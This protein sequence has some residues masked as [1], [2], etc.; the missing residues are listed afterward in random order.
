MQRCR[1]IA[2]DFRKFYFL[3][4]QKVP[5]ELRLA[6]PQYPVPTGRGQ[7]A[8][9]GSQFFAVRESF[10]TSDSTA[11]FS[12]GRSSFWRISKKPRP[13]A[14]F[15][16]PAV[17]VPSV[18]PVARSWHRVAGFISGISCLCSSCLFRRF[19]RRFTGFTATILSWLVPRSYFLF[20]CRI[21][22]FHDK[23]C[24]GTFEFERFKRILS[25]S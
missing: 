3:A 20:L 19:P 4:V 25:Y 21:K 13:F 12:Y 11:E 8:S 1:V 17:V 15:L 18:I 9:T 14:N 24:S 10:E 16:P 5:F 2:G 22:T 6:S 23:T 7:S